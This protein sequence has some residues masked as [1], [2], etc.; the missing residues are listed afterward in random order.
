MGLKIYNNSYFWWTLV[1]LG[2]ETSIALFIN[3]G[4]IRHFI[5]DVLAIILVYSLL[6]LISNL[7]ILK[8]ALVALFIGLFIEAIQALEILTTL[9]LDNIKWLNVV[10]GSTADWCDV[11]AYGIGYVS[12]LIF[13]SIVYNTPD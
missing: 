10:F 9:G 5:G 4:I 11:L 1:L 7:R 12:I 8:A 6:R 3:G 13:E 2:I